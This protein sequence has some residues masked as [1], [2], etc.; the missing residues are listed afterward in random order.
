MEFEVGATGSF[1]KCSRRQEGCDANSARDKGEVR[2]VFVQLQAA[3][4]QRDADRVP[5]LAIVVQHRGSAA[6]STLALDRNALAP[7]VSRAFANRI[8][9]DPAAGRFQLYIPT[10]PDRRHLPML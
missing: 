2:H 9:P 10:L 7:V 6:P 4:R 8:G 5:D 1:Q 3:A